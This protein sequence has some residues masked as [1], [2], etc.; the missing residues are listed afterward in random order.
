MVVSDKEGS[1]TMQDTQASNLLVFDSGNSPEPG[2]YRCYCC[3]R[4]RGG[5]HHSAML[6]LVPHR[7][8]SS[9]STAWC[10]REDRCFPL[11]FAVS[12][13]YESPITRPG[14]DE[15]GL[16]SYPQFHVT[17]KPFK[18]CYSLRPSHASL[19]SPWKKAEPV[20]SM[21]IFACDFL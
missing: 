10:R 16:R 1:H 2:M 17:L 4:R 21:G 6:P 8:H 12:E 14:Q 15:V 20:N 7:V 5:G 3:F 18:A 11:T 9:C 13:S 19:A